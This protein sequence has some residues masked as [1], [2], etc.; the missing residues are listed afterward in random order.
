MDSNQEKGI[1][2]EECARQI[3]NAVKKDKKEI[4]IGGFKEVA[5]I[6]LKRFLPDVLFDQVRKNIPE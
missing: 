5:A 2:P 4:Y 3:L 6:Y 1:A